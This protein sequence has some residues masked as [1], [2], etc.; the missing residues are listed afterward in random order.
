MLPS[1][2]AQPAAEASEATVDVA[3]TGS[4]S[5]Q[6]AGWTAISRV[7]GFIRA[8]TVAAVLGATYLG[9]L[10]QALNVLPNLAFE[11]LTGSLFTMLLVPRLVRHAVAGWPDRS[12]GS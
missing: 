10:Y 2:V 3:T 1:S 4:A 9:N 5:L 11:L 12:S 8:A 7:T 6:V